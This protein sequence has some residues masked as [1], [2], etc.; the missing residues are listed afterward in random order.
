MEVVYV[1]VNRRFNMARVPL[2]PLTEADSPGNLLMTFRSSTKQFEGSRTHTRRWLRA[3]AW[4]ALLSLPAL[5]VIAPEAG[6]TVLATQSQPEQVASAD[7]LKDQAIGALKSGDF[8]ATQKLISEA[9]QLRPD[10]RTLQQ[11]GKWVSSFQEKR[12]AIRAERREAFERQVKDVKLLQEHGYRSYAISAAALAHSYAEDADRFPQE[13]WVRTLIAESAELGKQYERKGQWLNAMRVWGDLASIEKMNP[14]WKT[15]LKDATRRVRLLAVYTPE[16]LEELRDSTQEERDAVDALLAESRKADEQNDP[17]DDP[18]ASD[19]EAMDVADGATTRPTGAQASDDPSSELDESFR[20]DWHDAVQGITRGMLRDA[21]VDAQRYYVEPV[22]YRDMLVG[23]FDALVALAETPGLERAFPTL[24][25]RDARDK[26]VA[27]MQAARKTLADAAPGRIDDGELNRLLMAV[28]VANSQTLRLQEEV[29]VSEFADG[30][31][32][33]LDPF[34]SM[35]WPSQLAEFTKGT[36]GEFVGVGIQIRSEEN[37]D[38]LVVSPLPDSP[39]YEAGVQPSDV[40]THI[41]GKSAKG[42]NDSQAVN[43]IT[44]KPNTP[45]TLTIRSVDGT[46]KDYT[47][48]R[49]KINVVSVKGWKQLPGG[50]WDYFVDPEEKIAY[51]RLTNFQ[52]STGDELAAAVN[53]LQ[54]E[55]AR[56][57]ILDLRYNPGGLL[58]SAVEVSDQFLDGGLIVRTKGDR[59]VEVTPQAIHHARAQRSDVKL[60]LVVLVNEYSASASEIVGG[61]LKDHER[62]L[63][64]GTRT[65]GKGSVQML[66]MIGADSKAVLKLTTAH[67]YLPSGKNIHKDEFDT[68]WGVDP[69]VPVEMTPQQMRDSITARQ[70]LDVLREDGTTAQTK[71]DDKLVDAETALLDIDAQLSAALLLLRM[72]LAGESVM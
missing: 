8:D 25:E 64:V 13:P 67:Y 71:I 61:A 21:L 39:A 66:Y 12:E 60:P 6:P 34:S 47:L 63:V 32:G 28:A 62:G 24:N 45:V 20:T 41:D 11:M 35:I 53:Q 50:K 27:A 40:I 22:A 17:A 38:L 44:G 51:L 26:F 4:S 37:G 42:L 16:I 15:R 14:E 33:T 46:V 18:D 55:G 19:G 54:R 59:E 10:D 65:F 23:G 43:F 57:V 58:Q 29:I 70:A 3:A 31:L 68:E 1:S 49:R 2:R 48:L 69:D 52:K 7:V 30:A 56:G 72:Q 36:Q 5:A 9:L